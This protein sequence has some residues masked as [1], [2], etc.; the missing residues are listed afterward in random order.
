MKAKCHINIKKEKVILAQQIHSAQPDR[1]SSFLTLFFFF[2]FKA[3]GWLIT[4]FYL[5]EYQ[6]L[7]LDP[8]FQLHQFLPVLK[9]K[10]L[11]IF[12]T[13]EQKNIN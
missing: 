8:G 1:M 3:K 9:K 10:S 7:H 13:L 11:V 4:T 6:A 12:Y 5:L 2:F